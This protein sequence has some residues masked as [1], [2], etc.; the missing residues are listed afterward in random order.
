MGGG[1]EGQGRKKKKRIGEK[2]REWKGGEL[3]GGAQRN[4]ERR[5]E[6]MKIKSNPK[7]SLPPSSALGMGGLC[8]LGGGHYLTGRAPP[9]RSSLP[10]PLS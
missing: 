7:I 3:G 2:K 6:K 9:F 5:R 8:V 4:A 10:P 1:E